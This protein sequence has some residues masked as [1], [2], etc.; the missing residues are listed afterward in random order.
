MLCEHYCY[1]FQ[2]IAQLSTVVEMSEKIGELIVKGLKR[3]GNITEPKSVQIKT[4]NLGKIFNFLIPSF[5]LTLPF[6][7]Q[8]CME[9]ENK[10]IKYKAIKENCLA[11][12]PP[13]PPPPPPPF[14]FNSLLTGAH[15]MPTYDQ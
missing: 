11:E 3:G 12:T 1:L 10:L 14:L 9:L 15:A 13:S 8:L 5:L 2:S 6:T 7:Q 4:S